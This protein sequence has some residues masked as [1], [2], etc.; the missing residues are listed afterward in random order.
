[1][2]YFSDTFGQLC[3][4]H[5]QLTVAQMPDGSLPGYSAPGLLL[6]SA[7]QWTADAERPHALATRC[8]AMVG[9][10]VC[11]QLRRRRLDDGR[12]VALRA[13]PCTPSNPTAWPA[14]TARTRR[15]C[16]RRADVRR[17]QPDL[18]GRAPRRIF[19][20]VSTRS[21]DDKGAM[22]FHM[23]R[24]ELGDDAFTA[25]LH[26]FYKQHAGKT[27]TIDELREW[28]P[29]S[30]RRPRRA[31]PPVNLLS[32]FSQWLDSTGVPEFHARLHRLSHTEGFS[33]GR[34]DPSGSRYLPHAGRYE[35]RYRGKPGLQENPCDRHDFSNS[36][37]K[38]SDGRSPT[39]SSSIP[40]TTC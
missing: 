25:L 30:F 9:R 35:S 5:T 6:I 13:K 28:R 2:S 32:F 10:A 29:R 15:L 1:M 14:C 40:T 19:R 26:D 8:R 18:A 27:A 21:C 24:A 22:V 17:R 38:R 20:P 39:A 16:C 36:R 34:Q 11:R 31:T 33:G 4:R 37:S 23:L 12:P 3:R 7:R